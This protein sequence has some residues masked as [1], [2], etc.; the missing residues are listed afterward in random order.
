LWSLSARDTSWFRV[1][2][3]H[4]RS[5]EP[6]GTSPNRS[7]FG[8][9]REPLEKESVLAK[10]KTRAAILVEKEVRRYVHDSGVPSVD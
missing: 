9:D 4:R 2:Y 6:V 1:S 10:P 3:D 7:V 5:I 8:P